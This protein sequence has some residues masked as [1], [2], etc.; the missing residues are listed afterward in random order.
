MYDRVADYDFMKDRFFANFKYSWSGAI[1]RKSMNKQQNRA[2]IS[3]PTNFYIV[4]P[5]F[6]FVFVWAKVEVMRLLA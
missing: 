6:L 2:D 5:E 4:H 1:N 3:R